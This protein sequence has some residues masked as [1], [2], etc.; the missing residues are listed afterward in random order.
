MRA[1]CSRG[2]S[3]PAGRRIG[4]AGYRRTQRGGA[5]LALRATLAGISLRSARAWPLH[6]FRRACLPFCSTSCLAGAS[7]RFPIRSLAPDADR[8]RDGRD[9]DRDR[10]FAVGQTF[11]R[12]FQSRGHARV[13]AAGQSE[14]NRRAFLHHRAVH[15]RHRRRGGWSRFF[16]RE[17]LSR[18]RRSISSP[19][20]RASTASRIAFLAEI[21]DRVRSDERRAAGSATRRGSRV[22][23]AFS[24]AVLVATYI[25]FEAPFSGMSMNP[26][27]TFGSAFVGQMWTA[28]WIYFVAPVLAMQ[29][30]AAVYQRGKAHRL[31]R[32]V[33]PSQRSSAASSIAASPNWPRAR[34]CSRGRRP[35]LAQDVA[36]R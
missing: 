22:L 6:D 3:T 23:P 1:R 18:I 2:R 36:T 25:T 7:T 27:R 17:A 5:P 14:R 24:P 19:R 31:L 28:L 32:Q 4:D 30:A 35:R 11:R 16:V 10:F 29:L 12:A 34:S 21:A 13:L 9:G 20:G 26:A 33:S 15:R 8:D